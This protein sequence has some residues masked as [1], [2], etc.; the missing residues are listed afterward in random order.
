MEMQIKMNR[1]LK[2]LI[3][4]TFAYLTFF[5]AVFFSVTSNA[6]LPDPGTFVPAACGEAVQADNQPVVSTVCMGNIAGDVAVSTMGAF[7]FRDEKGKSA[8]YRVT[9]VSNLLVKLMSGAVRSQVFMVGPHGDE[10]AMK[11]NRMGDGTFKNAAGQIGD[12]KFTVP[13]FQAVAVTL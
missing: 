8:I 3:T 2:T 6:A 11:I 4:I 13:E 12:A 1:S 10:I 5:G 7:E 9:Q